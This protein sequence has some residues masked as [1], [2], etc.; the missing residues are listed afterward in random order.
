[1][2]FQDKL[3]TYLHSLFPEAKDCGGMKEVAINCPLCN[4]EGHYD[5]D[6][7]MYISLGYDGKPPMYN[8]FRNINHIG[9]L[10]ESALKRF[11]SD[12]DGLDTSIMEDLSN[13][14][15]K[16]STSNRYRS[17]KNT[18]LHLE[19]ELESYISNNYLNPHLFNIIKLKLNYFCNRLGLNE[20]EIDPMGLIRTKKL[21]FNL[22]QFL[23]SNK[24]NPTVDDKTLDII[25]SNYI[26]FI[27]STNAYIVF[28]NTYLKDYPRFYN[29]KI[30]NNYSGKAGYYIMPTKCDVL[31]HIDIIITEGI[32]DIFGVYYHIYNRDENNKI[33]CAICGNSYVNAMQYFTAEMGLIDATF[34]IYM[35]NDTNDSF[36][37]KIIKFSNNICADTH[38]YYNMK[39]GEKDFGIPKDRIEIYKAF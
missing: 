37:N 11:I 32:F 2:E 31:K 25:N 27:T 29:Y 8:C 13:Y 3:R 39:E 33:Y 9:L 7:H 6:R 21:V 26:G 10:T 4:M 5:H 23:L 1:M 12:S 30:F 19:N 28:R 34:H 15:S 20:D 18:I 17:N 24:L 36:R 38:V 35:D 14:N 16:I 22:N